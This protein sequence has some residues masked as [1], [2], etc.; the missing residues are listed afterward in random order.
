MT[1]II[2]AITREESIRIKIF[3]ILLV[4]LSVT[5]LAYGYFFVSIF[6]DASISEQARKELSVLHSEYQEIEGQYLKVVSGLDIETAYAM[7]FIDEGKREVVKTDI[8]LL[9]RR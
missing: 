5:F 6:V 9:V 1:K 2:K 3:F 4:F 8:A 7:G